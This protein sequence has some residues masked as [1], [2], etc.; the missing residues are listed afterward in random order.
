MTT[1]TKSSLR[2]LIVTLTICSFSLAA[3]LGI[4]ALLGGGAIGET[5]WRVLG[6][7]F[8]VG[9]SS[10]VVLC[11]LATGG[12]RFVRF[13]ALGA[14]FDAVAVTTAL[15]MLW[16][17]DGSDNDAV[18]KTCSVAV[19]G[20]VTLAQVCLLLVLTRR[21]TSL[22]PM[23]WATVALAA[24]LGCAISALVLGADAGDGTVR[25]I[26]VVAILDV[27]GTV[28]AIAL[29]VFGGDARPTLVG[30]VAVTLDPALADRMRA[31]AG[32]SGRS[33][34]ALTV[35]ALEAYLSASA[36]SPVD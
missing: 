17:V 5:G 13:G 31:C 6:T 23:V 28:V 10:V 32:R 2:R 16:G 24:V 20:A 35:E 4:V 18:W 33:V 26:G 21:R 8:V 11:Y 3:L 36:P 27:L 34:D 14:G 9:C 19:I 30:P 7:T 15:A 1:P 25:F 12:S 22:A 29:A